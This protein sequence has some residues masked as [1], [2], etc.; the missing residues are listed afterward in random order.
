M[1]KNIKKTIETGLMILAVIA[2]V[3]LWLGI[4]GII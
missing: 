1:N 3:L 4:F 2:I